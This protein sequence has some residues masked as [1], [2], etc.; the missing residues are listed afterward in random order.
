MP[1]LN[2]ISIWAIGIVAYLL[3]F[4]IRLGRS[5][6]R[7]VPGPFVARFTDAWYLYRTWKGHFEQDNL[8]LHRQHG[9][10]VRYGVNR[11][12]IDDPLASKTIYGPGS[13]FAKSTWYDAW[14]APDSPWNLFSDRSIKHHSEARRQYQSTYAMSALIGYES[15]VDECAELFSCRLA[16]LSQGGTSVNIAHWLQ[17]YAFDVIASI[18]YSKRLG[19]LDQGEDIAGLMQT[20]K[21]SI[22]FATLVGIYSRWHPI[23]FRLVSLVPGSGSNGFLHV[24]RFTRSCINDCKANP[25]AVHD[26]H[27]KSSDSGISFL[28]KFLD[29]HQKDPEKFTQYHIFSGCTANM[30]AGSDTT[31]ISLSSILYFLLKN[32]QSMKKL[33]DEIDSKQKEGKLSECLTFKESQDMP[34]F[35]VVIKEALRMHPATGLPLER[36]VPEGGADLCGQHFPQGTIIGVNSWVQHRNVGIF[37]PDADTFNPERWLTDDPAKLSLMN[38]HWMPFGLGSRTCIGR[39]VSMLEICKLVPR[40][41]RDFDFELAGDLALPNS[42]WELKNHW[43]VFQN[44]FFVRVRLRTSQ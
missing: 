25:R 13:K 15:Y 39:H 11:Y 5:P 35:Q 4:F 9:P 44:N 18:T 24:E 2:W 43:F 16:E 19:F 37:G 8:A 34:Y 38:Q 41:V 26:D 28:H 10:I 23:L 14:T 12:S 40:L 6:L 32:P 22:S 42:E 30:A 1:F 36:V 17:C 7:Q 20:L 21:S 31:A 33:R 27:E 29:K 3:A